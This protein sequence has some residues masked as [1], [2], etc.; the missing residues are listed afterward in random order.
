MKQYILESYSME[1][2]IEANDIGPRALMNMKAVQESYNLD[3]ISAFGGKNIIC[4]KEN[5]LFY[6]NIL[7]SC[8]ECIIKTII[9]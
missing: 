1:E 8:D 4:I 9:E 5:E 3:Y 6:K 7:P 2:Y